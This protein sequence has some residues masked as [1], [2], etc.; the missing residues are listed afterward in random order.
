MTLAIYSSSHFHVFTVFGLSLLNDVRLKFSLKEYF[1]DGLLL[2][3]YQCSLYRTLNYVPPQQLKF[4]FDSFLSQLV[5]L[6][7]SSNSL[8]H[9]F[10]FVKKFFR[11]FL[12]LYRLL[13][14]SKFPIT[15]IQSSE[16]YISF[17]LMNGEGGIRTHAPLRTNGFQDRLVMTTSIPLQTVA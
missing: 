16:P 10:L 17:K 4:L 11:L 8:S 1:R 5:I 2:F 14:L 12:H 9:S 7:T 3:S 6:L 13:F 15:F